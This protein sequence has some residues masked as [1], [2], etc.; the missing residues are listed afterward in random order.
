VSRGDTIS[1]IAARYGVST[2]QLKRRNRLT[3]DTIRVGQK[4]TIPGG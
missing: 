2:T 3:G 1:E 4:I